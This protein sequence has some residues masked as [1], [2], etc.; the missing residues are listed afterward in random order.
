MDVKQ[1]LHGRP[2]PRQRIHGHATSKNP[3]RIHVRKRARRAPRRGRPPSSEKRIS[4]NLAAGGWNSAEVSL[5]VCM[6]VRVLAHT[7]VG[8]RHDDEDDSAGG[9]W[10]AATATQQLPAQSQTP[11]PTAASA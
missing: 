9:L 10:N 5:R 4:P 2:P 1:E 7:R 11:S 8:R 6:C 3:P